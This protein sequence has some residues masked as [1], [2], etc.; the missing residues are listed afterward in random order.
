MLAIH[1]TDCIKGMAELT[2][3]S[4]DVVVTSPPYNL[5]IDYNT[6]DDNMAR[7]DYLRWMVD[8]SYALSRVIKPDGSLFLNLGSKPTDPTIAFEVMAIFLRDWKLQNTIHWI[9]SITIDQAKSQKSFGHFKPINSPR[10]INDCHEYVF[11]FTK[12]GEVKLDRKA[13]GA[14]YEDKS[15]ITRWAGASDTRCRGNNWFIPYQTITSRK[16]DRPHPATFPVELPERCIKL[17]GVKRA[18][19]VLDPFM[20]LGS[21]GVAA[22]NLGLDF[23]G[24]DIDFDYCTHVIERLGVN[25]TTDYSYVRPPMDTVPGGQFAGQPA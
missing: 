2:P 15:N 9:K 6:Y 25:E 11:H 1:N 21:T 8:V 20:G 14:C 19:V 13:V 7:E 23:I 24:Y 5:D 22:K 17:H 3:A 18:K 4:I 16:N 12:T 10:F